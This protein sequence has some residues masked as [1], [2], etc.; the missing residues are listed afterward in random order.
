MKVYKVT[1]RDLKERRIDFDY[2]N[3]ESSIRTITIDGNKMVLKVFTEPYTQSY[4][5]NKMYVIQE[6]NNYRKQLESASKSFILPEM[7][8]VNEEN[9]KVGYIMCYIAGKNLETVLDDDNVSLRK[10][11]D[12]L[13][14][15]CSLL[16][17]CDNLRKKYSGLSN[18]YIND[19]HVN[20]F[21]VNSDKLYLCDMDS[22]RIGNS[23]PQQSRY[24]VTSDGLSSLRGTLN[25][26]YPGFLKYK[27][28][29]ANKDTDLYCAIIV[30]MNF[31][32]GGPIQT[33]S[34]KDFDKYIN[35]LR[36]TTDL[37]EKLL[38]VFSQIYK[39]G[40]N[41][42]PK[43]YLD[44]ITEKSLV[45]AHYLQFGTHELLSKFKKS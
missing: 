3:T 23:K 8:A 11:L 44:T 9:K 40:D 39:N 17:S 16:N 14:Q 42:N 31:L 6:L 22:C 34:R 27:G 4:L 28:C 35:Y 41:I 15:M 30:I 2:S 10:K 12:Y 26:K 36:S 29:I 25:S 33:L 7:I 18:F 37:S 21:I 20:N 24:L 45:K 43:E 1:R 19:L 13:K 32:Y 5:D 38:S